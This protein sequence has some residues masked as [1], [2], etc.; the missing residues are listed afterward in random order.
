MLDSA[1]FSLLD[2]EPFI[3]ESELCTLCECELLLCIV[4]KLVCCTCTS[5]AKPVCPVCRGGVGMRVDLSAA[6]LTSLAFLDAGSE[7]IEDAAVLL[8]VVGSGR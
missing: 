5:L 8:V 1:S 7:S 2:T 3:F 6:G 4:V